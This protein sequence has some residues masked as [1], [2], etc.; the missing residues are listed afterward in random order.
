MSGNHPDT[1]TGTIGGNGNNRRGGASDGP[2]CLTGNMS[3]PAT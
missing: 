1:G 3:G 2:C